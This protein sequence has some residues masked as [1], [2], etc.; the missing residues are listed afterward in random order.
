[1]PDEPLTL[2]PL[3][4]SPAYGGEGTNADA[5]PQVQPRS[6][7]H[8]SERDQLTNPR[9]VAQQITSVPDSDHPSDAQIR[10]VGDKAKSREQLQDLAHLI[11]RRKPADEPCRQRNYASPYRPAPG[12]ELRVR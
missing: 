1:M 4:L 2:T 3:T 11:S 10:T 12:D 8:D 9:A 5:V 7:R 6:D